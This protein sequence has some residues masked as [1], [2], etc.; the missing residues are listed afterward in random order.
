MKQPVSTMEEEMMD[1]YYDPAE[2]V[3]SDRPTPVEKNVFGDSTISLTPDGKRLRRKT[4][5]PTTT[6]EVPTTPA[7][8]TTSAAPTT[9]RIVYTTTLPPMTTTRLVP[10][11]F[12]QVPILRS[13]I[14]AEIFFCL[15][16]CCMNCKSYIHCT[17]DQ[18]LF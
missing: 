4:R 6:T 2:E 1:T 3:V 18:I 14:S 17:S 5:R 16:L 10:D 9:P 8:T 11:F 13:S 15:E 7:P 12:A